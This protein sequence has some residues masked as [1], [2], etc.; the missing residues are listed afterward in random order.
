MFCQKCG[1]QLPDGFGFCSACGSKVEAA[2]PQ[3]RPQYQ[4]QPQYPYPPQPQYQPVTPVKKK[5]FLAEKASAKCKRT[6]ML[7]TVICIVSILLMVA[8]VVSAVMGPVFEVPFLALGVNLAEVDPDEIVEELEEALEDTGAEY[9][10]QRDLCTVYEQQAMDAMLEGMETLVDNVSVVNMLNAVNACE[11]A[12]DYAPHLMDDD[13]QEEAVLIKQVLVGIIVACAALY[14]LPLLFT[15]LGGLK[16]S[17]GFTVAGLVL[18]L[19]PQ[20]CLGGWL[21]TLASLVLGVVQAVL[22]GQ[23]TKEYDRYRNYCLVG[24]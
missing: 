23:V 3:Y 24:R 11:E 15:L 7:T 6:A 17:I 1:A 22:C 19:V 2:Q 20:L 16:K 8:G 13:F 12:Y 4:L 9:E 21:L 18:V 14:L 5:V 10:L